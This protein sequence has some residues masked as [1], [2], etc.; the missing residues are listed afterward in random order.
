MNLH[1]LHSETFS[2]PSTSVVSTNPTLDPSPPP[3]VITVGSEATPTT[4]DGDQNKVLTFTG[5]LTSEGGTDTTAEDSGLITGISALIMAV[6]ISV[7]V[8]VSLMLIVTTTCIIIVKR[9]RRRMNGFNVV[10]SGAA[11]SNQV[12][13]N[14]SSGWYFVCVCM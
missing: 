1:L 4:D 11:F 9:K 5:P 8:I 14:R 6:I 12:Y 3:T 2:C 10:D 7:S 13:M